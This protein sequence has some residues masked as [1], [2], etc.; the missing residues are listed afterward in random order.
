MSENIEKTYSYED[1]RNETSSFIK[2]LDDKYIPYAN[3]RQIIST[4]SSEASLKRQIIDM[5]IDTEWID[6]IEHTIPHLDTAIR[7]PGR[8]IEDEEQI[9][10]VELSKK[11]SD[12]SVKHLAQHTNLIMKVEDDKITPAKLLNVY[13][14]ETMLTYENKFINTLL[15][16][17]IAFVEV[18]Y[19]ALRGRSGI[20]QNI[21][22]DFKTTFVD[23]ETKGT[24][25]L[26]I[27]TNAP[28][29]KSDE[30]TEEQRK[31]NI[32]FKENYARVERIYH[33][34]LSY[35]NSDFG[36]AL[37]KNFVR[38]PVIRTNALLKNKDLRECL[39]LWEYIV[40]DEKSGVTLI[41]KN[42]TELPYENYISEFY[43]V[44]SLQ[45]QS[46]YSH[47]IDRDERG[48][49]LNEEGGTESQPDLNEQLHDNDDLFSVYDYEKKK[50]VPAS[51]ASSR[52]RLT[53]SEK[54]IQ[55][56]LRIA[57]LADNQLERKVFAEEEAERLSR[58]AEA[59]ALEA[60]KKRQEEERKKAEEEALIAY[61]ENLERIRQEE[62]A[63][64]KAE[65]EARLK[66]EEE[67]RLKAE[68][69]TKD[70][71][72][73]AEKLA[74]EEEAAET[75]RKQERFSIENV[76]AG[77]AAEEATRRN[78]EEKE[79]I[80]EEAARKKEED[81]AREKAEHEARRRELEEA[82]LRAEREAKAK[83]EEEARIK[84]E[85]EAKRKAA[86]EARLK[87]EEEA[88]IKAEE[89]ARLKAEEEARLKAEEEARL[90]AEEEARRKAEEEA[91]LKA[92]EEAKRKAEEE[93]RL[94]AEEEARLK[95]EEEAR[96]KAEEEARLKA[97][98]E[99]RIKAEE[100]ARRKAEEEARL[101]A[102]EEARLKAEEEARL[103]AEEEARR[104]AEEEAR[105]K[106]EEEARLKAEEEARIKA[107]E[108]AKRKA[109]EEARLKAEEE[110]RLKAEEEARIKAEEEAKRKAEE[111]KLRAEEEARLRSEEIHRMRARMI[112][113]GD[114]EI[115]EEE[116]E[117]HTGYTRH[118]YVAL[119]RKLKKK[120]AMELKKSLEG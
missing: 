17:L 88:R 114:I 28:L 117:K 68:E 115:D 72:E 79:R 110:A 112:K 38:P 41:S 53:S 59:A 91:R 75:A 106:A 32:R 94:K 95:A 76:V 113:I 9:L 97:E 109:E 102:E 6:I 23:E 71:R 19:V 73:K 83:A 11:I 86:E 25:D 104:K 119:P 43:D 2:K 93:A 40:G 77:L 60:A 44:V 116:F 67:A 78:T 56:A 18:R 103:K 62:A 31:A 66:A 29:S 33:M 64:A 61:Q 16:R 3:V 69:E 37:G 101:K 22:F 84:A 111:D 30:E 100:E 13:H 80:A 26:K 57:I 50:M 1:F 92:E 46:F 36:R 12:K 39:T 105:L 15:N 21:T 107:E 58:E 14:N 98:E 99:A 47:F 90:K 85:E 89:E 82:R 5:L 54:A 20:S 27:E 48:R 52:R 108:E 24:I 74:A 7:N 49:I 87:A 4:S 34:L 70:I 63:K 35:V 51:E 10:P 45:Y 8:A 118:Q 55:E 96:L 42:F 81:A 65:K 120:V